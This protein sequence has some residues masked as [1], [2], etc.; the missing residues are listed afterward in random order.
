MPTCQLAD[1]FVILCNYDY[2]I[3][4]QN[5]IMKQFAALVSSE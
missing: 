2:R 5:C 1:I 4:Y 3:P